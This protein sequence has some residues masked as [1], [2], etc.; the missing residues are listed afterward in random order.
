MLI[1][2]TRPARLVLAASLLA[3]GVATAGFSSAASAAGGSVSGNVFR[4]RNADGVRQAG[5]GG[6]A[7][8]TVQIF[9]NGD[10]PIATATTAS[11]G[12]Y[13]ALIPAAVG[14][15]VRVEFTSPADSFLK[16][17]VQLA[18]GATNVQFV[19]VGS[20]GVNWAVQNPSD[21]CGSLADA[22]LATP[23]WKWGD[24]NKNGNALGT[25]KYATVDSP[26]V[27]LGADNHN[28]G[29]ERQASA[30]DLGTTYGLG[31]NRASGTLFAGAF[32]RRF[33]GL[34]NRQTG[35]VYAIRGAGTSSTQLD[36][37]PWLDL[38]ALFGAG[39]AGVDQHPTVPSGLLPPNGGT[40]MTADQNAW[41]H[42]TASWPLVSKAAFGDIEVTEDN[43]HLYMVNLAD[44]QLYRA[45]AIERPG[46]AADVKRVAIPSAPNCAAD[47][48]RPF[49]LG[50]HD[51]VGYV[52][53]V[54]S[55]ES[56]LVALGKPAVDAYAAV[57]LAEKTGNRARIDAAYAN[58]RA[59]LAPAL[60]QLHAYVFS[61]DATAM[62]TAPGQFTQQ[63]DIDLNYKRSN[64]REMWQ[65]WTNDFTS[66]ILTNQ[67]MWQ[68]RWNEPMLSSFAFEGNTMYIGL[69]NRM[70]DRTSYPAGHP[71]P[72]FVRKYPSGWTEQNPVYNHEYGT[73]GA[74]LRV[75]GG[76]NAWRLESRGAC[77]GANGNQWSQGPGGGLYY[78]QSSELAM[79]S[80]AHFPGAPQVVTTQMDPTMWY[81]NGTAMYLAGSLP[82]GSGLDT[83]IVN[84]GFTVYTTGTRDGSTEDTFGKSNG[85]GDLEI[86]CNGTPVEIGNRVWKDDND[87]GRQDPRERGIAGV[88]VDLMSSGGS[89]IATRTTDSN[90]NYLFSSRSTPALSLSNPAHV[91]LTIR[92]KTDSP[93]LPSG[94]GPKMK[95]AGSADTSDSDFAD[96]FPNRKEARSTPIVLDAANP[97]NHNLDF[98]FGATPMAPTNVY[99]VSG[100]V[101]VD[102]NGNNVHDAAEL[103]GTLTVELLDSAGNVVRTTGGP[104]KSYVF[105]GLT[106]TSYRVRFINRPLDARWS[107]CHVV[108]NTAI[109]FDSCHENPSTP[110][111]STTDLLTLDTSLPAKS[112][113]DGAITA[114]YVLRHIDAGYF[115]GRNQIGTT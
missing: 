12:S 50:F 67:N 111:T 20:I 46:S 53:V 103:P 19:A 58:Y 98:G 6:T 100:E 87:N 73:R 49:G 96:F 55:A 93:A 64:N 1:R 34:H 102:K 29:F 65:P 91:G 74:L 28:L 63:L 51:G 4:D 24:Q 27:N 101:W 114:D 22:K 39:T 70:A 106:G 77:D 13:N 25:W 80:V 90:G 30:A 94:S 110:T 86:L 69:R 43:Q 42:D 17:G 83:R 45:S 76:T 47:D 23:C 85:L 81:S 60:A 97:V 79:G 109:D 107:N 32:Y 16:A 71:D 26:R 33:A 54:C 15:E 44:R 35:A 82:A 31:F 92:I 66:T 115:T 61:F 75:C 68:Q 5:E 9:D 105:E 84:G 104:V 52:G 41:F 36:S 21:Y 48:S 18:N 78:G 108:A 72:N 2:F 57:D 56:T 14:T 3:T 112:A 10:T 59:V 113:A 38:N 8:V 99:A 7:N 95:T 11:D 62:P 40:G 89:V 37:T 88:A